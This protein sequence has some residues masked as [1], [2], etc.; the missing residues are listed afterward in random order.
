[1][2]EIRWSLLMILPYFDL[3]IEA[4][5]LPTRAPVQKVPA[6]EGQ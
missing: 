3:Y 5:F 6:N 4:P 1:M 2:I